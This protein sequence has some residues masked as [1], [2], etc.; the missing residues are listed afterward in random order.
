MSMGIIVATKEELIE[1]KK[2]MKDITENKYYNLNFFT[3]KISEKEITLVQCGIGKVNAARTA[4]ILIDKFNIE[5]VINIGVAGGVTPKLNVKDIV[6]ANKLVQYDFDISTLGNCEKGEI[7]DIGKFI[8][9]DEKLV[10]LCKKILENEENR[11][12]NYKIG[13]VATADCFCAEPAKA[14]KI[15]IEFGAECVEMEGAAIAQVCF[16]DNIPFLVIRGISDTP[17]GNNEI[18]YHNFCKIAAKQAARLLE[19]L[20][21]Q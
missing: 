1:T 3:G 2:I 8:K 16:L 11:D 21:Q 9:S 17:N 13:T 19:K 12:F 6:I 5:K 14:K 7:E 4:Q 20:C 15:H 10:N 18:D